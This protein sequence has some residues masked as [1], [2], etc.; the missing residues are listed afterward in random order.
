MH[1]KK[2]VITTLLIAAISLFG[3]DNKTKQ[4]QKNIKMLVHD[5]VTL[6]FPAGKIFKSGKIKLN[7][8]QQAQLASKVRPIMHSKYHPLMQEIFL[9]EKS[10]QKEVKK[11]TSIFD[12]QLQNKID[13]ITTLKQK[14]LEYK[15][16]A[17]MKIKS[18][19]TPEQWQVWIT[20]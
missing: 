15:I 12:A 6:P 16:E 8:E 14:A 11:T 19:L 3:A 7:E 18:I 1:R 20:Y 2:I 9:L 10:I 5:M 4:A 17:L 13:N